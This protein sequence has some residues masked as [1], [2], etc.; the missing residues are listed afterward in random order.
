MKRFV[1]FLIAILMFTLVFTACGS[2]NEEAPEADANET[3]TS[4][5]ASE[6][7]G[8]ASNADH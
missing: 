3:E 6:D 1:T 7:A 5:A 8:E 4:E 2:T